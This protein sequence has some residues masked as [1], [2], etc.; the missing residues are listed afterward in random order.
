M[1]V[2]IACLI[3]V[4][5]AIAVLLV[6]LRGFSRAAKQE[7][8]QGLLASVSSRQKDQAA[9]LLDLPLSVRSA[10]DTTSAAGLIS[11]NTAGVVRLAIV[12]RS[13]GAGSAAVTPSAFVPKSGASARPQNERLWED[14]RRYRP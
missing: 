13:K 1:A 9:R 8:V 5:A 7:R 12:L 3:I 6:C 14:R 10:G 4:V 2:A 11:K